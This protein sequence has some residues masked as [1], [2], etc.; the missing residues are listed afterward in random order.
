MAAYRCPGCGV[1]VT[2]ETGRCGI[3]GLRLVGEMAAQLWRLDQHIAALQAQREPLIV[4]L[5][6]EDTADVLTSFATRPA[7]GTETKRALLTL[8]AVCLVTA[9]SAGTALIWPALGVAGQTAVL[10]LVTA[11]LLGGAVGLQ[12]RLPATAE[13]IAAVGVAA[14]GVDIV[15]GRR[16]VA[17]DLTGAGSRVYWV[18]TAL[19]AVA[20]IGGVGSLARRLYSPAIGAVVASYGV[21][22]AIVAP[23]SPDAVALV[24]LLGTVL[25]A[26]I[27]RAARLLPM[28]R[29]AVSATAGIGALASIASGLSAAIDAAPDR[30]LGLWCGLAVAVCIPV[31]ATLAASPLVEAQLVDTASAESLRRGAAIAGGLAAAFLL[32][33]AEIV[34]LGGSSLATAAAATAVLLIAAVA[35][36]RF[37]TALAALF[38][39]AGAGLVETVA[40]VALQTRAVSDT[41]LGQGAIGLALLAATAAAIAVKHS[42]TAVSTAAAAWAT[43]TAIGAVAEAAGT[44]GVT[45]ASG[46]AAV[47]ASAVFGLAVLVLSR[48]GRRGILLPAAAVA[49][50]SGTAAAI[51]IYVNLAVREVTTVEAYVVV[52]AIVALLLGLLAMRRL[53]ASSSWVLLPGLA[54][55]T[56]PTLW[57]ALGGDLNRQ[58]AMLLIGV[59]LV[60][61][62]AQ[63]RLACPLWVGS[64]EVLLVVLRVVGPEI[65]ALPRWVTL[66]ILGALLLGLGATWERRLQDM[67]RIAERLRPEIAALR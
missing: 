29:A 31:V 55:A 10:L 22:V 45:T 66:G 63:A 48:A 49:A 27:A 17:P 35:R 12:R 25:G 67:R 18:L 11:A 33:L 41:A 40:Q 32:L 30:G 15:A 3:C 36:G 28:Q 54:I 13:A 64:G 24:G 43:A 26:A 2:G 56:A 8:G 51:A 58:V 23:T 50:V 37:G 42:R 20:V 39:G 5:R 21:V 6:R 4:A 53:P 59:L 61:A 47:V 9:L 19:M 60:A 65:T 46:V 1:D 52:P 16:L 7:A 57:L 34:P 38:A 14:I 44:D 62:G